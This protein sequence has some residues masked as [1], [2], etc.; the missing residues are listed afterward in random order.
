MKEPGEPSVGGPADGAGNPI[1]VSGSGAAAN[2]GGVAT[3]A[4][5][6]AIGGSV[7][8][9]VIVAAP[10]AKIIIIEKHEG[11]APDLSRYVKAPLGVFVSSDEELAMERDAARRAIESLAGLSRPWLVEL[12]ASSQRRQ[13]L[14][15]QYIGQCDVFLMVFQD[16]ISGF[17]E[18]EQGLAIR[19]GVQTRLYFA[20]LQ[21]GQALDPGLMDYLGANVVTFS[22]PGELQELVKHALVT[23]L[24]EGFR[25]R[26]RHDM[27]RDDLTR[28]VE[29]GMATGV[30]AAAVAILRQALA[31]KQEEPSGPSVESQGVDSSRTTSATTTTTPTS[32]AQVRTDPSRAGLR[33]TPSGLAIA[34]PQ[35]VESL[36]ARDLPPQR[37][38]WEKA[39]LELCLVPGGKFL[40]GTRR[41]DLRSLVRRFNVPEE[42]FEAEVPQHAV[43]LEAYYIGRFP[44]TQAQYARLVQD[45]GYRVPGD[46]DQRRSTPPSWGQDL[47]VTVVS[48]EDAM[49]YCRWAGLTLPSEAEWEKA[50]RGTDARL[51]PW[52]NEEPDQTRCNCGNHLLDYAPVG[53]FSPQGDSPYGCADMAGNTWEW[54]R[55][56]WGG[57]WGWPPV[58]KYPYDPA[59]GRE[60]EA[61]STDIVRVLRGGSFYCRDR[62]KHCAYRDPRPPDYRSGSLGFRVMVCPGFASGL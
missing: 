61:A 29:W 12:T 49:A 35:N 25:D 31:A 24:I 46:W 3:G 8:D 32:A 55:S 37:I 48:W 13:D 60:E 56:L 53:Q 18:T 23:A 36:L 27:N 44:V 54:T 57:R 19:Q 14:A 39:G 41:E 7:S 21:E 62:P 34:G 33:R 59:D 10:Q 45:A 17:L 20:R 52:G 28:I 58:F 26:N 11:P 16:D 9:S 50:A 51:F 2:T 5:G 38:W 6:V 15:A 42:W 40:M 47:P 4:G 22:S 1:T 30:A 43:H